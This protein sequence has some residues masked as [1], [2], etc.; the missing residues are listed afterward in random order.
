[1][2][3]N[4]LPRPTGIDYPIQLLQ[5][6]LYEQLYTK[7]GESGLTSELLQVYGRAYRNNVVDN[8]YVPQAF[9]EGIDYNNDMFYD[10]RIAALLWFGLNDPTTVKGVGHTYNVTLYCFCNLEL[11]TPNNDTQRMDEQVINDVRN[12]ILPNRYGFFVKNV[13]RDVDKVLKRFSGKVKNDALAKNNQQPKL[14]F[15]IEMTNTIEITAYQECALP[16][17]TPLYFNAMTAQIIVIFKD[18][19]NTSI[20]QTLFNGVKIQ[21]Q[22]PTGNTVTIPHLIGRDV[23]SSFTLDGNNMTTVSQSVNY[24]PYDPVTGTF[25]YGSDYPN[26]GF[27]D[28][29]VMILNYNENS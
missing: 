26:D 22:Y 25:T 21:L 7:W 17:A 28:G 29:M 23:F 8:G 9:I 11:V 19:P 14:C 6:W 5:S 27:Q 12:L 16:L 3:N 2:S 18:N 10:D 15:A 4:L 1:M 24:V 13:E 20:T